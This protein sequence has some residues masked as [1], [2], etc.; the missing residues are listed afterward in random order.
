MNIPKVIEELRENAKNL[1]QGIA[2]LEDTLD[3][4]L[5][6]MDQ[7]IVS[8]EKKLDVLRLDVQK[9]EENLNSKLDV[10]IKMLDE[11]D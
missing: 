10:I 2:S 5:V 1:K 7:S 8:I 9:L 3:A 11:D 4:R 6:P